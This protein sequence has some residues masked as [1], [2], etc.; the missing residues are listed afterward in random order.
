MLKKLALLPLIFLFVCNTSLAETLYVTDRILLGIHQQA[1]ENS[2][3]LQTIAS[4]TP[5]EVVQK[6]DSFV[7]IKLA[8]G[9]QGWVSASYLKKE[10]PATA[11]LDTVYAKLQQSQ[12]TSKKLTE[13]LN[14]LERE[15]QVRRDEVSNARTTIKDLRNALK[16][17]G[18]DKPVVDAEGLDEAKDT[19]T[20][21]QEKIA[22]LEKEK[23]EVAS[24]SGNDAVVEL[25]KLQ[26][27]NKEYSARIEAA[28]ANL[29]GE[30]VPSAAELAAIRPSFP[31]WYWLLLA[32][33]FIVGVA[34]G[35]FYFDYQH[36]RKHGGFRI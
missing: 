5:V 25:E 10:K 31:V 35:L 4:G 24:Q 22:Q 32:A 21:L 3:I 23:T 13:E 28:L 29:N 14:K 30:T 36:R 20:Q 2:P 19:I 7:Q 6:Q 26:N 12:E 34:A 33:L 27:L 16:E 11:E 8:D 1:D 9:T 17:A 15:I 18:S